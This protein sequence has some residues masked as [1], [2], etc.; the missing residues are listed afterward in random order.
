M[1]VRYAVSLAEKGVVRFHGNRKVARGRFH[2][3][4]HAVVFA[5]VD[6]G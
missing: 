2:C 5:L 3:R 1:D 4:L 6:K